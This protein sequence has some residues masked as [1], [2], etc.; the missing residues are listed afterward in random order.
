MFNWKKKPDNAVYT[1]EAEDPEMLVAIR[2]AQ[3]SY[4]EFLSELRKEGQRIV[5]AMEESLVKY[6]FMVKSSSVDVEHM[7]LSDLEFRGEGLVGTLTSEPVNVR[8]VKAG[9]EIEIDPKRVT[10]WMYVVDG[11]GTG[12][13]TFKV[14]WNRFSSDEKSEYREQPPF[15]WLNLA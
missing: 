15:I 2:A 5:P 9:D 1:F 6:A 4:S 11:R 14:M 12:G 3:S 10:D 7:F 13:F 8:D